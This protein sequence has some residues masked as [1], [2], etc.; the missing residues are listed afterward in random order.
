MFRWTDYEM[1]PK[2]QSTYAKIFGAPREY[3]FVRKA[4]Y[5]GGSGRRLH[6]IENLTREEAKHFLLHDPHGRQLQRDFPNI[7]FDELVDHLCEASLRPAEKREAP[8][9]GNME[10][11]TKSDVG[12]HAFCKGLVDR[13]IPYPHPEF[14]TE[15][16]APYARN[17]HPQLH[18]GNA[19]AKVLAEEPPVAAAYSAVHSA[20]HP[21]Y[22]VAKAAVADD[23]D[24]DDD[25]DERDG[26]GMT[27]AT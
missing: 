18:V 24:D 7:P 1:V 6:H 12:M 2:P 19:I 8:M 21:A 10:L 26:A 13:G 22:A 11:I 20:Y 17:R 14:D 23:D 15:V 16:L 5:R 25:D 4:S 3:Q 27:A 9:S